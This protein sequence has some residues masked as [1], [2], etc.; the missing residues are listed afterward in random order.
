MTSFRIFVQLQHVTMK[1]T[2]VVGHLDEMIKLTYYSFYNYQPIPKSEMKSACEEALPVG[3]SLINSS[4]CV[5]A[6]VVKN[7]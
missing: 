6:I 3:L 2:T 7:T 5:C 4:S 1:L